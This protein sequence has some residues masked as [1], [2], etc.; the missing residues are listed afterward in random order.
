VAPDSTVAGKITEELNLL[1]QKHGG[2]GVLAAAAT[3]W[4]ARLLS[5]QQT[6]EHPV[7]GE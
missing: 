4:P 6:D 3:S 5:W 7:S 1:A 2:N